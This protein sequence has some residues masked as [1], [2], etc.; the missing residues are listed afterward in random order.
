MLFAMEEKNKSQQKKNKFNFD[1]FFNGREKKIQN[2][3]NKNDNLID[4][5]SVCMK[6]HVLE[7]YC[8]K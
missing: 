3:Q 5:L 7:G 4:K 6:I 2:Q 8:F 1:W